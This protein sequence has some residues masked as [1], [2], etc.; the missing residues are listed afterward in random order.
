MLLGLITA[1]DQ[2]DASVLETSSFREKR[3]RRKLLLDQN[4]VVSISF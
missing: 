3:G 1:Q 4:E 2:T